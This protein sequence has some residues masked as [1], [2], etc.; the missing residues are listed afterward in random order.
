MASVD[1]DCP[2][3]VYSTLFQLSTALKLLMKIVIFLDHMEQHNFSTPSDK[4]LRTLGHSITS[5]YAA[6]EEVGRR[7]GVLDGWFQ[8]PAIQT[9]MLNAL[10]EFAKGAS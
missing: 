2:G 6:T 7:V 4:Q 8:A 1:Y 9:E 3:T 5:L 10:S